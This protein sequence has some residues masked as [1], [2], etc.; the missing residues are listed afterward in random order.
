MWR[1]GY[2]IMGE[3]ASQNT[4]KSSIVLE[5]GGRIIKWGTSWGTWLFKWG[6]SWA[7][8]L[9]ANGGESRRIFGH[10]VGKKK[11]GVEKM[12]K[13]KRVIIGLRNEKVIVCLLV[14]TREIW[15]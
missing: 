6:T 10:V 14:K 3:Q 4:F 15:N 9:E 1:G 13:P 11:I 8:W 2:N 7:W 5:D 12:T